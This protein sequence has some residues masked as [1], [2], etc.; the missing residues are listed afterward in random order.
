MTDWSEYSPVLK[1][2]GNGTATR[3][4]FNM[5]FWENDDIRVYIGDTLLVSGYTI[6]GGSYKGNTYLGGSINF[7]TPPAKNVNITLCR[8]IDVKRYSEFEESGMFRANVVNGELNHIVALIQQLNEAIKRCL[9]TEVYDTMTPNEFLAKIYSDMASSLSAA[10]T[11]EANA[12]S[13]EKNANTYKIEAQNAYKSTLS[14][15]LAAANSEKTAATSANQA[16]A[17]KQEIDNLLSTSGFNTVKA[18]IEPINNVAQNIGNICAAGNVSGEIAALLKY[19]SILQ[20]IANKLSAIIKVYEGLGAVVNT[21]ANMGNINK[22]ATLF[23]ENSTLICGGFA[24][25]KDY[26]EVLHG[27]TAKAAESEYGET[28]S[29]SD[30]AQANVLSYFDVFQTCAENISTIKNSATYAIQA[31]NA[32]QSANAAL[33]SMTEQLAIING[34]TATKF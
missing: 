6:T 29:G 21:S 25:T 27:G 24:N 9:Q 14:S 13:S 34:G 16:A 28:V 22:L 10:Q 20:T 2:K 11:S 1:F 30:A 31:A 32:A 7:S 12:A 5:M 23:D 8:I 4:S 3:F 19:I 17:T 26:G 33:S 18:N 15:K